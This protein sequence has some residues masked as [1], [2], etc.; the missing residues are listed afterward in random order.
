MWRLGIVL[1][2]VVLLVFVGVGRSTHDHGVSLTGVASTLWPFAVGLGIG[3]LT[4]R[5]I[6]RSGMTIGDGL[7]MTL[8]TIAVGMILRVVAGQGT[9][10]AFIIVALCFVGGL[11]L[12]W[13]VGLEQVLGRR[14]H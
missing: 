3:W 10:L 6:N 5:A 1:D 2:L 13:R 4:L 8:A 9:A 14:R 7:V 12:G 11:M